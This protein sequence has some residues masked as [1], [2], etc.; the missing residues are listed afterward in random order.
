MKK[1]SFTFPFKSNFFKEQDPFHLVIVFFIIFFGTAIFFSIP[2]FYDYKKYNQQIKRTINN[3]F[4]LNIEN[5]E[6]ISFKFIPSPHLLIRSLDLKIKDNEVDSIGK[7]ENVK[8]FISLVELYKSGKFDIKRVVIKKSNLYLNNLSLNNFIYNLKKNIINPILIKNSTIFF[9]DKNNE[10]VLI[11]KI[12]K[13][14]YKIDLINKK[15]NTK[16]KWEY[17][18]FKL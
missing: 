16:D 14:D 11:S 8:F 18:R 15:K 1:N 10:V 6:D 12:K 17:L 3:Q 5:I 13:I 2:T 9:K 7:L 4:K